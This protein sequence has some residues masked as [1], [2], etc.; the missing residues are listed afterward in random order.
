MP[1]PA[2]ITAER[3][4]AAPQPQGRH[5]V[6]HRR[7]RAGGDQQRRRHP[8]QHAGQLRALAGA[9]EPEGQQADH[10]DDAEHQRARPQRRRAPAPAGAGVGSGSRSGCTPRRTSPGRRR[11][12]R[13]CAST[14]IEAGM[15]CPRIRMRMKTSVYRTPPAV[16]AGT[17]HESVKNV[18]QRTCET[19]HSCATRVAKIARNCAAGAAAVATPATPP[20]AVHCQGCRRK[21]ASCMI[22]G[23]AAMGALAL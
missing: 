12:P 13:R 8:H 19:D 23:A 2:M 15:C 17:L 11:R 18:A 9:V 6:E 7:D 10:D 21:A 3:L 5:E 1:Q 14:A 20:P 22:Q 4:D 16:A